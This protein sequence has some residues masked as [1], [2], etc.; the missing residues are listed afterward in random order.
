MPIVT[1][2]F[3]VDENTDTTGY[4]PISIEDL[5]NPTGEYLVEPKDV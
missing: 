4:E 5:F 3:V 2:Q 1:S